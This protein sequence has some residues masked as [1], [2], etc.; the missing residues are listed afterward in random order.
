MSYSIQN[1][2]T[3]TG[4]EGVSSLALS[5]AIVNFGVDFRVKSQDNQSVTLTNITSPAGKPETYR[6]SVSPVKD[7]YKNS[8]IDPAL[9][10]PTRKGVSLLVAHTQVKTAVD[11]TTG[12]TYDIPVKSHLV[13]VIPLDALVTPAIIEAEVGRMVTA[14]YETGLA[15]TTR[16][17]ALIR[18]VV[19]P[20]DV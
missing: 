19:R 18:G 3:D 15:T 11:A 6:I 5:R 1:N 17:A 2:Y 12:L 10:G 8:D 9:Y 4:V 7:I 14:L 20:S 13:S 16:I